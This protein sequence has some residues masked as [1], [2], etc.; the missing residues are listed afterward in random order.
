MFSLVIAECTVCCS[1]FCSKSTGH[2][3]LSDRNNII[4]LV[5]WCLQN[6]EN[7]TVCCVTVCLQC[8]YHAL[9][10]YSFHVCLREREL[11]TWGLSS[12]V[13]VAMSQWFTCRYVNSQLSDSLASQSF[14]KHTRELGVKWEQLQSTVGNA[15]DIW[16]EKFCCFPFFLNFYGSGNSLLHKTASCENQIV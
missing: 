11:A 4:V 1:E 12:L 10:K 14:N 15:G 13:S 8:L 3:T 5:T 9:V 7:S 2:L 16:P 6:M